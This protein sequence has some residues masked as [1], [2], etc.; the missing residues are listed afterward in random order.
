MSDLIQNIRDNA[1]QS[2][3]LCAAN[4]ADIVGIAEALKTNT[5]VIQLDLNGYG[6]LEKNELRAL[7]DMLKINTSIAIL[8]FGLNPLGE[9]SAKILA[10]GLAGHP[11]LRELEMVHCEMGNGGV[12]AVCE[13]LQKNKGLVLLDLTCERLKAET[14]TEAAKLFSRHPNLLEAQIGMTQIGKTCNDNMYAVEELVDELKLKSPQGLTLNSVFGILERLPAIYFG[15][16]NQRQLLKKFDQFIAALPFVDEPL[17]LDGLTEANAKSY[18]PMDNPQTWKNFPAICKQLA[19]RGTP[20]TSRFLEQTNRDGKSYLEFAVDT[21]QFDAIFA[22]MDSCGL[23]FRASTLLDAEAQPK[24]FFRK[25]IEKNQIAPF[26]TEQ[27]W[28][29][30]DPAELKAVLRVLPPE[31]KENIPNQHGLLANRNNSQNKGAAR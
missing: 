13:A 9:E 12:R 17:S 1:I 26:F 20:V 21:K 31:V 24:P 29:G 14:E 23:Q 15:H 11:A 6:R 3:N 2:V 28:S 30:A 16:R 18:T 8:G 7:A 27:N 5:S 19:S 22:A 25:L 4:P 10:E